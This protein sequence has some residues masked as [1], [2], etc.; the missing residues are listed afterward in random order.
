MF[1]HEISFQRVGSNAF[2]NAG[3]GGGSKVPC[4]TTASKIERENTELG[5]ERC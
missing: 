3:N 1:A 2:V 5:G 4:L